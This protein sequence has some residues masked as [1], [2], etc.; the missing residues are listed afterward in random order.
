MNVRGEYIEY[1]ENGNPVQYVLDDVVEYNKKTYVATRSENVGHP[2]NEDSGW[3]LLGPGASFFRSD[4]EPMFTKPGDKW[5]DTTSG[6]MYT[7]YE[8]DDGVLAW[9]QL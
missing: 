5:I 6:V 8:Q 9:V 2:L 1:D 7:R 3:F 4:Y